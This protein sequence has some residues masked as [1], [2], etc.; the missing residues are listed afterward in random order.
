MIDKQCFTTEWIDQKSEELH[1]TDKNLIEKVIRAFSLLDMLAR[2]GCPFYFKGGSCLMLLLQDTPHRLS[3]DVDIICPPGT[4]IE[5]YLARY[6][7]NGFLN[8]E[9][10]ERKQAGKDVPKSH[11]KFFYKVAFSANIDKESYI[12]L[13][14]LYEDCQYQQIQEVEINNA[15]IKLTGEQSVVKVPSVGD[16]LGDKLTAFAPETTGIPYYKRDKLATLEIIKQLY[17][18]SRLFDRVED[19]KTTKAAFSKIAPIELSYRNL[20]TENLI[21]IFDD[22]RQTATNISTRGL[23][24]KEKFVLLQQGIKSIGNFM[25]KQ[26]YYIEDAVADASKAAYLATC[27]QCG[28]TT[29]ERYSG[30]PSDLAELAISAPLHARLNRLRSTNPEAFFYWAKS[31]EML[32]LIM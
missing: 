13:D 31:S 23:I 30:D 17:D 18:I 24:D 27:L 16:I 8:Y 7:E 11:S 22:I 2:S 29:I 15:L 3:I 25:Y 28:K 5:D 12:L 14:V 21:V 32:K 10:V 6:A 20:P 9:L 26:K 1:Y 4:N 19:L